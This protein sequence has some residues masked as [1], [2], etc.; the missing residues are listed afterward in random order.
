[1]IVDILLYRY[2]TVYR[3]NFAAGHD[4][5]RQRSTHAGRYAAGIS[6]DRRR[7]EGGA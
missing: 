2:C 1:M 5:P 3:A 6:D 7:S 4:Y